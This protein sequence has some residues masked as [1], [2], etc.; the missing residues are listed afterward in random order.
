MDPST[1]RQLTAAPT[2]GTSA[3]PVESLDR[4]GTGCL[5]GVPVRLLIPVRDVVG[6]F[7]TGAG[8]ERELGRALPVDVHVPQESSVI[9]DVGL[10]ADQFHLV[11][12]GQLIE[13][14]AR[15]IGIAFARLSPRPISGVSIPISRARAVP[16]S[17]ATSMVSPSTTATTSTVWDAETSTAGVQPARARTARPL[18]REL[19]SSLAPREC[20]RYM[21]CRSKSVWVAFMYQ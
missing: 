13:E 11:P 4:T 21:I 3:Q 19:V 18:A 7:V 8:D 6:V 1:T 20:R 12:V 16:S 2:S 10:G 15:F 5:L 14:R 9:I 17:R